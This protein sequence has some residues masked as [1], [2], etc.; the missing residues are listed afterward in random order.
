MN[1]GE[2]LSLEPQTQLWVVKVFPF[3]VSVM[4]VRA[5]IQMS[6]QAEVLVTEPPNVESQTLY[7]IFFLTQLFY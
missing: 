4:Q 3:R 2:N 5:Y 6:T 7:L 1:R